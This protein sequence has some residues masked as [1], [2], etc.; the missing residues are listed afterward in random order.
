M[1]EELRKKIEAIPVAIEPRINLSTDLEKPFLT[2][3]R[4]VCRLDDGVE[5][6]GPGSLSFQVYPS[7]N[8]RF[9]LL[10]AGHGSHSCREITGNSEVRL[11]TSELAKTASAQM[12]GWSIA[13]EGEVHSGL[14]N[15]AAVVGNNEAVE[16]IVYHL[17]NFKVFRGRPIRNDSLMWVGR[18]E[19]Q[20]LGLCIVV[21]AVPKIEKELKSA[22][23]SFGYFITHVVKIGRNDDRRISVQEAED[24]EELLYWFFSFLRARR[25]G[26]IAG[27]GVVQDQIHWCRWSSPSVSRYKNSESWFLWNYAHEQDLGPLLE[28]FSALLKDDLWANP[29][30]QLIHWY[31]EASD[32]SGGV[33]GALIAVQTAL[34]LLGWI[35]TVEGECG[36]LS[37]EGFDRLQA[38]DKI[39]LLLRE[40]QVDMV[41]PE[42][43]K[44]NIG[45]KLH[46][47]SGPKIISEM[48][49]AIVHPRAKKREWLEESSPTARYWVLQL[50]LYYFELA[51]LN[52]LDYQG[53]FDSRIKGRIAGARREPVPWGVGAANRLTEQVKDSNIQE[54]ELAR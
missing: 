22:G 11:E 31:I 53:H 41:L 48:R 40:C 33:E 52:S 4:L 8:V 54:G 43:V 14:L 9:E 45:K 34:E 36:Y 50:A 19:F 38:S 23:D 17:L 44:A 16:F 15:E 51:L 47:L 13:T 49:N 30:K 42:Q 29:L 26:L 12:M 3:D 35:R 7:P 18:M 6:V 46:G 25:C 24:I 27:F 10:T 1:D 2:T 32:L 37:P 28:K 5:I 21:D 20:A 39:A